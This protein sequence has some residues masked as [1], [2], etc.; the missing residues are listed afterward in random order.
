MVVEKVKANT[1]KVQHLNDKSR[2]ELLHLSRLRPYNASASDPH[3]VAT[4]DDASDKIDFIVEHFPVGPFLKKRT[5]L[6]FRVRWVGYGEDDDLWI[7]YTEMAKTEALERYM[8]KNHL[9]F[10]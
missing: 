3:D 10:K 9:S 1:Y 7:P 4:M 2:T 5:D 8:L 6:D